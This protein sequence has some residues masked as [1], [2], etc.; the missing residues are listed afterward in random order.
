M[1][2]IIAIILLLLI[3]VISLFALNVGVFEQ[4][5]SG[6][7]YRARMVN[8]AAEL[9]ISQGMEYLNLNRDVGDIASGSWTRCTATD[10]SFPCGAVPATVNVDG[11][12]IAYRGNM[13]YF[14]SGTQDINGSGSTLDAL[15]Q[16]MLPIDRRVASTAASN[17][18]TIEYGVGALLC[19]IQRQD[20]RPNPLPVGY[21][22]PPARCTA[23]TD[24]G[25]LRTFT[26]VSRA[27]IPGEAAST[28]LT[29]TVGAKPIVADA[30]STPPIVANGTINITGTLQV[31]TNPNSAGPGVPVSIWT[32]SDVDRNG[33]PNTCHFDEF[34]RFGGD[35]V[36][37]GLGYEPIPAGHGAHGHKPI[38]VC[39]DCS[40]PADHS[41]SYPKS[42]NL[43]QEGED[44][45]DDD[46]NIGVNRDVEPGDFPCDLFAYIFG[47]PAWEDTNA[48]FFCETKIM[49][50][51]PDGGA[52]IGADEAFL[53]QNATEIIDTAEECKKLDE[54]ATGVYWVQQSAGCSDIGGDLGTP[55]HPVILIWD[56]SVKIG[57][58]G[59]V[60]GLLFVRT[61]DG[62]FTAKDVISPVTGGTAEFRT[63]GRSATY[64]AIVVQG[65]VPHING[66]AAVIYS[67]DVLEGFKGVPFE[68][69][70]SMP[71]SW[72]DAT[73]Y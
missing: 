9:A 65:T 2:L 45:L 54:T 56:G 3:T 27:R 17:G 51:D 68:R 31:V 60:F 37:S 22:A 47:Q 32:R 35:K 26:L 5:T 20:P 33:T 62:D 49:V 39:D 29:Q 41:L 69:M 16:R 24:A 72:T 44:I 46:N 66:T 55:Y 53:K 58:Q 38:V 18:F 43:Q 6:N 7:D 67:K 23:G 25:S 11:V 30:P 52:D 12:D 59:R 1:T 28:T 64:G 71:G 40:C 15:E 10:E 73:S 4:R 21:V 36:N 13:F 63:N 14:S 50:D 42:G 19:R 61:T 48:D 57:A 8:K 34:I 70:S